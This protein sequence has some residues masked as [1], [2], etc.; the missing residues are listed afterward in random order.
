MTPDN[1]KYICVIFGKARIRK[2]QT[3]PNGD[4]V[5]ALHTYQTGKR[6][7]KIEELCK[8]SVLSKTEN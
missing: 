8:Y 3:S 5:Y 2:K 7:K 4:T 6:L 1:I